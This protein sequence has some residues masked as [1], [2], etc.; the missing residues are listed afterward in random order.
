M[1]NKPTFLLSFI[2]A[3]SLFLSGCS[4]SKNP[5]GNIAKARAYVES[6]Q[7]SSAEIEIMNALA[8]DPGN[9]EAL[10]ILGDLYYD[11]GRI[12]DAYNAYSSVKQLGAA[13]A[14][15]LSRLASIQAAA[16]MPEKAAKNARSALALAPETQ[17]AVMVLVETAGGRENKQQILEEIEELPKTAANTTAIGA[18][19]L[20]SGQIE[21]AETRFLEALSIDPQLASA[22]SGLFLVNQA[23]GKTEQATSHLEQAAQLSPDRSAF[24]ILYATYLSE[25]KDEAAAIDYLE[26]IIEKADDYLPALSL[27][28]ELKAK[29]GDIDK[30]TELVNRA[31]KLDKTDIRAMRLKGMISFEQGKID[32]AIEQLELMLKL[33]PNDLQANYQI[34]LAFLSKDKSSAAKKHLGLVTKSMPSHLEANA[35]L[36]DILVK[37][38]DFAGAIITLERFLE[39]KPDSTEGLLLLANVYNQKGDSKAALKIYGALEKKAPKDSTLNYLSGISHMKERDAKNARNSFES[40]LENNP[41]HLKSLQYLTAID[42]EEDNSANALQ[43][44]EQT[45]A[46][47][48]QNA[49]LHTVRG[50]ILQ[51]VGRAED[52]VAAFEKAIELDSKDT[53]ARMLLARLLRLQGKDR[54]AVDQ[55]NSILAIAP[56]HLG[57]LTAIASIQEQA[58]N[59]PDAISSYERILKIDTDNLIALNNLSYLYSNQ[60]GG[61][62]K[63]FELAKR[64][65]AVAPN[66]PFIADTLGWIAYK[67]GKYAWA[68]SLLQ[69]SYSKLSGIQEVAYHLGSAH[70]A[71]GNKR[72]AI[73]FLSKATKKTDSYLGYETAL[74][75]LNL[76]NRDPSATAEVDAKIFEEALKKDPNDTFALSFLAETQRAS[77]KTKE[78]LENYRQALK[79]SPSHLVAQIGIAHT[80]FD[81]GERTEAIEFANKAAK[82]DPGNKTVLRIQGQIA[83]NDRDHTWSINRF[84]Q[85]LELDPQDVSVRASLIKSYF[86]TGDL[87]SALSQVNATNALGDDESFLGWEEA[88]A[89]IQDRS[90]S[91]ALEV[92]ATDE[93]GE[94]HSAYQALETGNY[95]AAK[96]AFTKIVQTYPE[97]SQAKLGLAEALVRDPANSETVAQLASEVRER[98]NSNA[99]AMALEAIAMQQR[100]KTIQAVRIAANIKED[101]RTK[102]GKSIHSK[103]AEIDKKTD[104]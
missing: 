20:K 73:E 34:A 56:N 8:K 28:A 97:Q 1:N 55:L 101:A 41:T 40:V 16:G 22:H 96:A 49:A 3:L 37:E 21:K 60:D 89:Y 30:A 2:I 70:Y 54:E 6:E 95:E 32:E 25:T 38:N 71:L 31:L 67:Q 74:R 69:E 90:I 72:Q 39:T 85:L 100:G 82:Q 50:Q 102:L 64:A 27:Q 18:L 76:L 29:A 94:L 13:D 11:Q 35:L 75:K 33:H 9:L 45:I 53:P 63:A 48:P 36:S 80:L 46:A 15:T 91:S 84:S 12:R 5:S 17:D 14:Q 68:M 62:N 58:K 10:T 52:A 77:G 44:I 78:S 81:S 79:I 65:R 42:L 104:Q 88:I 87:N 93:M 26:N 24:K 98:S 61:N 99:H 4:D 57:A 43:R 7:R 92:K 83:L 86:A 47:A 19:E 66:D 59:Y 51:K 103:L 23:R